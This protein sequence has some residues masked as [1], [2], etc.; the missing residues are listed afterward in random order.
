M[1][2]HKDIETYKVI[3]RIPILDI[4]HD[5]IIVINYKELT[6]TIDNKQVPAE[7]YDYIVNSHMD[8]LDKVVEPYKMRSIVLYKDELYQIIDIFVNMEYD[9]DDD[10]FKSTVLYNLSKEGTDETIVDVTNVPHEDITSLIKEF[11]FYIS[12]RGT[13]EETVKGTNPDA[14]QWR[15]WVGNV[16]YS[17]QD[18]MSYYDSKR[19]RFLKHLQETNKPEETI[20]D[21]P[22]SK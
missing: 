7:I 14:D 20:V 1:K 8:K 16:Y 19:Q 2:K 13:L 6:M 22:T 15:E 9:A 18:A 12:D 21:E 11:Y 4:P 5:A 17:R 3:K 10:Y